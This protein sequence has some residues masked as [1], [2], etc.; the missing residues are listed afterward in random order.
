MAGARHD[1]LKKRLA[2]S[3]GDHARLVRMAKPER[4]LG[5]QWATVADDFLHGAQRLDRAGD[6][7]L[8]R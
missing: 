4:A 6:C 8:V 2:W 1:R 7:R 3:V 5:N